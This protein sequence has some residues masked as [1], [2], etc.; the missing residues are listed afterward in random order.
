MTLVSQDEFTRDHPTHA[1]RI[2][3][4]AMAPYRPYMIQPEPVFDRTATEQALAGSRLEAPELD[5]AWFRR[6]LAYARQV[7]WGRKPR[8]TAAPVQAT[9]S[10]REYFDVF[11]PGKI[12]RSLLPDLRRLT[13]RF[14]IA[15]REDEGIHWA[16]D[17]Q[18]G[19][20]RTISHNGMPTDC[21]FTIDTPTLLEIVAGRLT[22]QRAFFNR[23][24]EIS[25]DVAMGLK[26]AAVMAQFFRK[27]PFE[28]VTE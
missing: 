14:G 10:A 6:L 8:S 7:D 25:G 20:L 27:F 26:I 5:V 3:H 17:V 16:L 2:C 19:V 22:P 28:S 15:L 11:L 4:R 1:E 9:A 21:R 13:A 24:A 12:G 18:E 23:R